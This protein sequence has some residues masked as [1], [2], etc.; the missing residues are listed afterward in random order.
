MPKLTPEQRAEFHRAM[1]GDPEDWQEPT[2]F[3][4]ILILRDGC[5]LPV[6]DQVVIYDKL[7]WRVTGVNIKHRQLCLRG[8]RPDGTDFLRATPNVTVVRV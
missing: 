5:D 4:G 2:H 7:W 8:C 1:F 3:N 6:Y